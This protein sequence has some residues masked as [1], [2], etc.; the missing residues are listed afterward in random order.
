VRAVPGP[1]TSAAP[2]APVGSSGAYEILAH[3]SHLDHAGQ[4]PVQD[5]RHPRPAP[6]VTAKTRP[7]LH[8]AGARHDRLRGDLEGRQEDLARPARQ[9]ASNRKLAPYVGAQP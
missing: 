9:G 1:E 5:R 3:N 8:S 4:T 2:N 6:T 7:H